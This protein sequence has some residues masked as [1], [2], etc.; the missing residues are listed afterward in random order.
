MKRYL[1]FAFREYYPNG[2]MEDLYGHYD[3]VDEVISTIENIILET[4]GRYNIN[5]LD[6]KVMQYTD[7]YDMLDFDKK[8]DKYT[9]D[10]D[11]LNNLANELFNFEK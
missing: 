1:V 4:D 11:E 9:L 5:V 2:G 8:K 6:T 3:T 7:T 10:K